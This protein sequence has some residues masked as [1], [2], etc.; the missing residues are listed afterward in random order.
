MAASSLEAM[1]E[2]IKPTGKTSSR[3][4]G[5]NLSRQSQNNMYF[6]TTSR[7]LMVLMS[8]LCLYA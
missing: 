5:A 7:W 1:R 3:L 6:L 4:K 2:K 8:W